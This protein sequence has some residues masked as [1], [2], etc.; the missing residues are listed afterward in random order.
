MY[1]FFISYRIS[2]QQWAEWIAWQLK[3]AGYTVHLQAWHFRSGPPLIGQINDALANAA[4]TIAVASPDYFESPW[5][6]EEWQTAAN[7][8]I[9]G[10]PHRL[11]PV[12]VRQVE[13]PPLMAGRVW[14]ELVK[15]DADRAVELLLQAAANT[16]RVPTTE[17]GFPGHASEALG[18]QPRYPGSLPPVWNVPHERNPNF[19]GRDELIGQLRDALGSGQTAA[20]TQ[21]VVGLGGVGKTQLAVEYAY[22]HAADYECVWWVRAEE[23]ST[24]QSD[25][26]ALAGPLDLP[27]RDAQDQ[28]AVVAA[29]QSW[30]GRHP[31][32]LL[33]L[34]NVPHPDDLDGLL[35]AAAMG[36]VIVTSRD[37]N[38]RGRAKP[39]RVETF[40]R[41]VSIEF[42]LRRTG[43]ASGGHVGGGSPDPTPGVDRRSH[44]KIGD[45]RSGEVAGSGDRPQRHAAGELAERL[46]D[47][48]LALAQAAAYIDE[49]GMT[50]AGYVKLLDERREELW[51]E[52]HPPE[53]Y[54]RTVAETFSLAIEQV[55]QGSPPAESLLNLCAYLAPDEI[56]LWL[57]TEGAEHLPQPLCETVGDELALNKAIA[58]LR[59]Y[60][61]VE[62]S[63]DLLSVHRLLQT[64]CRDRLRREDTERPW[65]EAAVRIVQRAYPGGDSVFHPKAWPIAGQLLA[66][67]VAVTDHAEELSV[68]VDAAAVLLNQMGLFQQTRAQFSAAEPLM[69]RALAIG[70]QSYGAEHPKVALRLNNL[71]EL[72]RV[73]NR[74]AEAEPLMRRALAIDEQSYGAEHPE[75]AIDLNNLALLLRAMNRLAEADP[76]MRRALAIGE[77]SLGPDHAWVA[78]PLNNLAQLLKATNRL[79]EA[80]PLMRRALAI[81]EQSYGAEHPD[82]AIDLDN[83]AGLLQATN[84]LAE[85]EPLM[86][87][88]LAIDEQSYGGEHP[89]V[90]IRLNNL[91]QLLKDTNRLAEAEPLMR[92]AI[93][94][95]Q[96]S[97]GG[98]HPHTIIG[99]EN[100]EFLR[101]EMAKKA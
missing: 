22:R 6:K 5:C 44:E 94:I 40:D 88:A 13:L 93:D 29:V 15:A 33:V 18:E 91:A 69:R 16:D 63:G 98:E 74:L 97:L 72:L 52:Q 32:W 96:A 79:A 82:V 60:S 27:E 92:R 43:L 83:L 34:D 10:R 4:C 51:A 89:N 45:L 80:E 41:P 55:Q 47:L 99:I 87:R 17:P 62:R 50:L 85:A 84:R 36:H 7:M 86:R 30:L 71:V 65:A 70:E 77:Q 58:A 53:G 90:A 14:I 54:E 37:P 42:L 46:G 9:S 1:D 39:L 28:S 68:A 95:L 25:L 11:L 61:L 67:G 12:R 35:P 75:I 38:W 78:N 56:P 24:R 59:K 66:H 81:D 31:G 64:V 57:L 76:L 49:T 101:A 73:T 100:L 23:P 48:P 2:D 3:A 19:T 8:E 21:A 26:A 20:L